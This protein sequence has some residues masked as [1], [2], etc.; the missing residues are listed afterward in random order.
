[1]TILLNPRTKRERRQQT[2]EVVAELVEALGVAVEGGAAVDEAVAEVVVSEQRRDQNMVAMDWFSS[3]HMYSRIPG[4]LLLRRKPRSQL[5]SLSV[6]GK[7]KS[8]G[9]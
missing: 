2:V 4:T 1:L 3:D 8:P 7:L 6:P 5:K 9:C